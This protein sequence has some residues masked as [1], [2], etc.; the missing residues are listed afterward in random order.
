MSEDDEREPTPPRATTVL[1][2]HGQ[3]ERALLAAYQGGRLPHAWL[4]SGPAGV[5]KATLAYRMARFVLANPDPRSKA[6]RAA[7]SLQVD[8]EHPVARRIAAQAH[9]DLLLLERT[10]NEKT[11]KLRQDIQVDDV[12]KSVK[13]FGSTDRK[14]TRLNSSH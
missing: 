11:G 4:L 12:R 6:V 7:A 8:A 10:I 2:G 3:A 14:S 5:G 13:F 1:Y 9:G